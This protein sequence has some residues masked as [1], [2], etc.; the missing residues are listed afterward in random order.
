MRVLGLPVG[1]QAVTSGCSWSILRPSVFFTCYLLFFFFSSMQAAP[2]RAYVRRAKPQSRILVGN[3]PGLPSLFSIRFWN[4]RPDL[5]SHCSSDLPL[6][7]ERLS[8]VKHIVLVLSGKGGVGKSTVTANLAYGLAR[9]ENIQVTLQALKRD[10]HKFEETRTNIRRH[11]YQH[12]LATALFQVGVLDLDI[13][14]PSLPKIFGVE[15]EQVHM[16]NSG[17]S[18]VV[19]RIQFVLT[20]RPAE[21]NGF[22]L[23]CAW[24]APFHSTLRTTSP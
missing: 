18:P 2:I 9:N 7:A 15:G 5:L 19:R 4:A 20:V 13:C 6:I 23:V 17:W 1:R 21:N 16:S 14:G 24:M 8:Q 11:S 3:A 12:L 10:T 22:T